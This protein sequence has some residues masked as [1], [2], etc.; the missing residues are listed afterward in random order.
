MHV[1]LWVA[2][3][4]AQRATAV[5]VAAT[6]PGNSCGQRQ[7]PMP[8]GA[9]LCSAPGL[10]VWPPCWERRSRVAYLA[11]SHLGTFWTWS[12]LYPL[13]GEAATSQGPCHLLEATCLPD[14]GHQLR[15]APDVCVVGDGAS[16]DPVVPP[17]PCGRA[18]CPVLYSRRTAQGV[19][20]PAAYHRALIKV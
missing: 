4:R 15:T 20:A 1:A 18:E 10:W 13:L 8:L 19:S 9:L 11:G 12:G 3:T 5:P 6:A 17:A 7:V 14:L 2:G 16:E